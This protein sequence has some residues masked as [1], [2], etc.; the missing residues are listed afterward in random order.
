[1]SHATTHSANQAIEDSVVLAQCLEDAGGF[2]DVEGALDSYF[3]KRY[4]RT[5][6]VRQ[7]MW[8]Y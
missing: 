1:M 8:D 2:R 3:H 5:K 4:A 6:K 7:R